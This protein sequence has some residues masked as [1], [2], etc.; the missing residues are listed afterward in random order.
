MLRRPSASDPARAPGGQS[1]STF[2]YW[3]DIPLSR[4]TRSSTVAL[5]VVDS[6]AFALEWFCPR[7]CV[8][9][10]RI[11][12]YSLLT[13]NVHSAPAG[14]GRSTLATPSLKRTPSLAG[15]QQGAS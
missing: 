6:K 14:Q 13:A 5:A 10:R 8:R 4:S 7:K 15:L 2:S 11:Q 12:T 3:R 1:R 9:S